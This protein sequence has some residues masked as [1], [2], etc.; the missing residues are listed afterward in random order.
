MRQRHK[1]SEA[2]EP[3]LEGAVDKG[4]VK[5]MQLPVGQVVARKHLSMQRLE[6]A[7]TIEGTL[8][9]GVDRASGGSST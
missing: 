5:R 3:H 9:L 8:A 1:R 2:Y 6:R 7:H 4:N